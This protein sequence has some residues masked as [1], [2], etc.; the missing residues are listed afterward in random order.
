MKHW[1]P[2]LL[3]KLSDIFAILGKW[4]KYVFYFWCPWIFKLDC[5]IHFY[6]KQFCNLLCKQSIFAVGVWFVF[7]LTC[8]DLSSAMLAVRSYP[9]VICLFLPISVV[10][11]AEFLYLLWYTICVTMFCNCVYCFSLR[12]LLRPRACIVTELPMFYCA[13]GDG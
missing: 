5:S 3:S 8:Y 6:V 11:S 12:V 10:L 2:I 13:L 9:S 7:D 1:A 4:I